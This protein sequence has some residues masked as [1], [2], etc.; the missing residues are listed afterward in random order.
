MRSVWCGNSK[1]ALRASSIGELFIET[2][3]GRTLALTFHPMADGGS[4]VLFEDIT[5]RKMAEAKIHQLARYDSLTGLPNRALFRDQMDASVTNLRRRGPFAIHFID[6]DEFKQV[7]D[8]LG[9]PCGDELLC[10]VAE[11]LRNAVRS[12]D[13]VARFG[14][15]EFVILQYPLGHP[16]EAAA[17]AERLVAELAE[18]FQISGHEVVVG[19]SIGI[20]LAPRDG[21]NAD[22]LLKNADMAL[23]RAKSDGRRAWRFFEHGMDVMAQA[24]RNL[25]LDL[26]ERA[27]LERI[28]DP[29]PA[30]VQPAHQEDLDLRGPAALAASGAR[31]GLAGGIHS[32]SRGNG[33]DRRDRQLRPARGLPGVRQV[34][35]RCARGRQHVADPVPARQ[36]RRRSYARRLPP[37]SCRQAGSRSRS[38]NPSSSTTPS[39]RAIGS[40]SCRKWACGS[41]S[42][43]SAPA[44]RA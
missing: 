35:G 6:L 38:P 33:A 37:R 44:T 28:R 31:H 4:V 30:P 5:D 39:S 18:P 23:Y 2:E 20:A 22:L 17:L 24:R 34:A 7:N 12:S 11:R 16:K 19:A 10:A 14:G 36:R 3:R 8:T 42:T 1:A 27:G 26:Q 21:S 41:R 43:I 29:L 25:Q 9:H 15:D 13:I 40:T 32:R